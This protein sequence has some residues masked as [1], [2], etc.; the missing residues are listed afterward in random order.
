MDEGWMMPAE[1]FH[2]ID[3]NVSEGSIILEFGSGEGSSILCEKYNLISIEHDLD[4]IGLADCQYIHA[5]ILPNPISD[6]YSDVGWYD[7]KKLENLPPEVEVIIIDGPPGDI[8]RLGIIGFLE[9]LPG[10][11]WLIVDDT[12]R[13]KEKIL[14]QVLIEKFSPRSVDV[15]ASSQKRNDGESREASILSMR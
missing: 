7:P 3:E 10:F 8:G 4:W 9:K 11:K 15:I 1:I 2:W 14:L 5:E 13:A 6:E 12:D